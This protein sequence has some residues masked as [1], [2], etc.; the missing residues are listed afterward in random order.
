MNKNQLT[1]VINFVK[2]FT[3]TSYNNISPETTLEKDLGITGDDGQDFM[4][5]F[6]QKF[7][8]SNESF[9]CSNYF[10][11]EGLDLFGISY[12][13]RKILRLPPL[14]NPSHDITIKDLH[15]AIE[16]G[17]WHLK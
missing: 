2:S 16:L 1:E 3:R 4:Q 6:F 9:D 15:D 5:G 7:T 14:K 10:S 11:S 8:V 12:I 17:Y 13:L